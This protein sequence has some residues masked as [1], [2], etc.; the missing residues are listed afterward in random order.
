MLNT[1]LRPDPHIAPITDQAE[2]KKKYRYW[3]LRILYAS[4][5][6]YALY[7]FT[8]GT[9][10]ISMPEL[11]ALGF[12]EVQL[13]WIASLFTV[14]YG[15]SK[16][17]SGILADRSNPRYFMAVGLIATGV[18][19]IGFGLSNSMTLF[20]L[21][22]G[23]NGFFQGWGSAPCHRLLTH[24]YAT[25]ERGR[26]WSIWNTSHNVGAAL[27]PLVAATLIVAFG[28]R[29]GLHVPGMIAIAGGFFLMNR[30]RDTPQSLGLPPI[31]GGAHDEKELSTRQ[32]LM[33]YT[34]RNRWIWV[35][36]AAYFLVYLVRWSLC[37]WSYLYLVD[38][39]GYS[40]AMAASGIFWFEVG[41]LGGGLAAGWLSDI[42]FKAR[43]GPVN[44][45]FML[46][47][48]PCVMGMAYGGPLLTMVS[49]F[50]AGFFIFGPQMLLAVMAA[51]YSHKKA[52]ATAIGFLG[53]IAYV[54]CTVTGGPMGHVIRD[55]GWSAYFTLL[56]GCSVAGVLLML[57]LIRRR[58]ASL[59]ESDAALG[60]QG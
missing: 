12:D 42:L 57:P 19:N 32:I 43:R 53:I 60:S 47:V 28:W 6:G 56:I 50:F 44:A 40:K 37:H 29:A 23:L 15:C 45:L 41:G 4:F 30:L 34:L 52:A 8:R 24:W 16:F 35:I 11:K 25:K 2:I 33:D 9:L 26:W 20:A 55:L 27:L 54:G 17:V 59:S 48:L 5:V 13:G 22:W 1:W 3:R 18:L 39:Q 58:G 7:Y 38:A 21:F 14:I 36:A 10:A 46:G 51:E 49:L 31:D